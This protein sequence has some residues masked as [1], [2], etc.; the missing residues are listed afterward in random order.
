MPL[1][2]IRKLMRV[3]VLLNFRKQFPLILSHINFRNGTKFMMVFNPCL[4]L[5]LFLRYLCKSILLHEFHFI[6]S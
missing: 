2:Y 4:Y 5:E 6:K 3:F 1:K